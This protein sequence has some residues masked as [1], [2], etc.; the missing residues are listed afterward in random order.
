MAYV[1]SLQ[2]N[3]R[4]FWVK[5]QAKSEITKAQGLILVEFSRRHAVGAF[6][7][8]KGVT[9]PMKQSEPL[10]E[11]RC[12]PIGRGLSRQQGKP[13]DLSVSAAG[14]DFG[15]QGSRH[16][17]CAQADSQDGLLGRDTL[18]DAIDLR[19]QERVV[20]GVIDTD[21]AALVPG[22]SRNSSSGARGTGPSQHRQPQSQSLCARVLLRASRDLRK[23]GGR[24]QGPLV[25][26]IPRIQGNFG[27]SWAL[28]YRIYVIGHDQYP[29]QS[30]PSVPNLSQQR[31]NFSLLIPGQI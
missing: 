10:G 5:L 29:D 20:T 7:Q 25:V 11:Q 23:G 1:P 15:T 21:W 30:I 12:E 4:N 19:R 22:V 8:I 18:L 28:V 31:L 26:E 13:S 24:R 3:G 2:P 17:L 27:R 14:I 9:V 16:E 6:R